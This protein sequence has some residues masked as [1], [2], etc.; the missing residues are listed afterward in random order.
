MNLKLNVPLKVGKQK[1]VIGR[2]VKG[3]LETFQTWG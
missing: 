3:R 2:D 1:N